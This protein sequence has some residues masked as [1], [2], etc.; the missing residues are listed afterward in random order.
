MSK[1]LIF[2]EL[3]ESQYDQWD[4]FV[5]ECKYGSFFQFSG[6]LRQ[7]AGGIKNCQLKIYMTYR[8]NEAVIGWAGIEYKKLGFKLIR[9]PAIPYDGFLIVERDVKSVSKKESYR[10]EIIQFFLTQLEKKY[11]YLSFSFPPEFLD[12]RP[13]IWSNYQVRVNFT[14]HSPNNINSELTNNYDPAL[15]RQIKKGEKLKYEILDVKDEGMLKDCIDLVY[16]SMIRQEHSLSVKRE[17]LITLAT[18][19]LQKG[20][21]RGFLLVY[22]EKPIFTVLS[23]ID[24]GKVYYWQAGGDSQYFSTGLN[25]LLLHNVLDQ[26]VVKEELKFDFIGANISS[27]ARYKSQYNFQLLS[28][29]RFT[30][31][32]SFLLAL[33]LR[34][35]KGTL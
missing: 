15:R 12:I 9:P 8:A 24:K 25:Q 20:K 2:K 5:E 17:I 19:M 31:A 30:K 3:T 35:K 11:H 23:V 27:I 32:T 28:Y 21:L 29:Y 10:L 16:K 6:I 18:L 1:K 7:L 4:A 13:L 14:Y 22:N 26:L 34:I 33:L